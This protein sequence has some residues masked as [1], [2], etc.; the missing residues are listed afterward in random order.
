ML[1]LYITYRYGF[2]ELLNTHVYYQS[3]IHH[4]STVVLGTGAIT[5]LIMA[6]V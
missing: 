6:L 1:Q 5:F 3:M 2:P 4:R